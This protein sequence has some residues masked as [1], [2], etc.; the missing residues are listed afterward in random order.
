MLANNEYGR[1]DGALATVAFI[2]ESGGSGWAI[3]S[4]GGVSSRS[5]L[6]AACTHVATLSAVA[7]ADA[8]PPAAAPEEGEARD[9]RADDYARGRMASDGR[10]PYRDD[11]R[12]RERPRYEDR[13]YDDRYDDRRRPDDRRRYDD[14]YDRGRDDRRYDRRCEP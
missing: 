4:A 12:L 5:D 2:A 13:R 10:D 14:R 9:S 3:L 6:A 11:D 7:M 1:N 8:P